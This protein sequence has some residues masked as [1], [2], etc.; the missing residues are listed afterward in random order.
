MGY[1]IENK[2]ATFFGDGNTKLYTT[3]LSDIG[4]YTVESLKIPEARNAHINVAG[5]TLSLNEYLKMFEEITG[6]YT[7]LLLLFN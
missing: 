5:A 7:V 4:K 2:K 6:K 1:D 3:S